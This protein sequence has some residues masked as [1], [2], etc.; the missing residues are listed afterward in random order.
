MISKLSKY[1]RLSDKSTFSKLKNIIAF[2]ISKKDA[3]IENNI[4][5]LRKEVYLY[6]L[7]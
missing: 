3:S 1:V 5:E 7:N 2:R 6:S 4:S